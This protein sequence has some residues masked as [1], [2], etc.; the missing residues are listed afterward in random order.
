MK[1]SW[2]DQEASKAISRWGREH[3]EAFALRLYSAR[4]IGQN[5]SLVLH[6][7]GNVSFKQTVVSDFGDD[8]E[9]LFV[10]GSGHDLSKL[11]PAGLPGLELKNLRRLCK[12]EVLT[13]EEMMNHFRKC[14]FDTTAATPSVETLVHA[15]LPYKYIDHSHADAVL[16]LTNHPDGEKLVREALGDRVSILP[17]VRPGF[18]L[19]RAVSELHDQNLHVE[20]MVLLKHGLVT[21]GGDAKTAYEQHIK[22]IDACEQFIEKKTKG[23]SLSAAFKVDNQPGEL[24][25]IVAPIL[26]GLLAKSSGS[27]DQPYE[28]SIAHWRS[29]PE[30][31]DI[32]NR[33]EA[34]VIVDGGPLT[35][36]HAIRTKPWPMF[37]ASPLWE[38][39]EKLESQLKAAV[40]EYVK[41]YESY[42]DEYGL[43]SDSVDPYPNV[44]LLPGGGMFCRGNT[45]RDAHI[46]ADITEH[47]LI[48]KAKALSI[49]PYESLDPSHLYDVEYRTYQRAKI[50][51]GARQPLA[52]QIVAISGGAGAI[53][54]AIA[55]ECIDAGAHVA[56]T[57]LDEK[58][59]AKVIEKIE[60]RFG[61]DKAIGLVMDVTDESSVCSGYDEIVKTFGGVDVVVPNAG[62]A[63]VAAID[64]LTVED[65]RR[66]MEVNATG[67][68]MF[69]REGVRIMKQQRLGGNIIINAS[70]NV[71][72]PGKDFGAYSASKA[73]GHQLGKVAA[74]ELA[75]HNIRVNM[76]NADAIFENDDIPSG[77]WAEV[78]PSRAKSRNLSEDELYD[79]YR[80]RN[81]LKTRICG[82]H[83][84]RAVVFFA[85]NAT[86]TTGATLPIDG[87]VVEAF[88]R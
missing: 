31:M 24:A 67:Y 70:K 20:G 5:A 12:L 66:V 28:K 11:E 32:L 16:A 85:S 65:F 83:V 80:S 47:T 76:I 69:M 9:A 19:A 39:R 50:K 26:R 81:L 2:S 10:K 88:P 29:T 86:P 41:R 4:L 40:D 60:A 30:L 78:A 51:S 13:D 33:K 57:D 54:S 74:I 44:V 15:F 23:R 42:V 58:R 22:L 87:G 63:H 35:G 73:A 77:L 52:G 53:G 14:L 18:E 82:E 45:L 6:G 55:M 34:A 36:D 68:F 59:I 1:S 8:I 17:Y 79:Y 27:E 62:I 61:P 72:G 49:G 56:I 43:S 37:V 71:F 21:W 64:E 3:G 84:G 48:T 7:G 46:A 25:R 75:A 38:D